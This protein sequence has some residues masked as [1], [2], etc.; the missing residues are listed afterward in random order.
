[1]AEHPYIRTW[2]RIAALNV[3]TDAKSVLWALARHGSWDTGEQC[4]AKIATL[5]RETA[6]SRRQVQYVLRRL[7]CSPEAAASGRCLGGR[8]CPHWGVLEATAT[9]AR[10]ARTYRL[11][12]VERG[13]QPRLLETGDPYAARTFAQPDRALAQLQRLREKLSG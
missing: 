12:F 1:M 13:A 9:P 4:F 11:V 5:M 3:S 10:G 8:G 6:L 2:D 7:E